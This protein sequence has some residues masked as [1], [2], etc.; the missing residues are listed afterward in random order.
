M[1]QIHES[2][3]SFFEQEEYFEYQLQSDETLITVAEKFLD[4]PLDFY[5]LAKLNNL[6]YPKSIAPGKIL[7]IPGKNTAQENKIKTPSIVPAEVQ[8]D[9]GKQPE[10]SEEDIKIER[11]KVYFAEHRYRE[12]INL[13]ESYANK[14]PASKYAHLKELLAQCYLELANELITKGNLLEAQATLESSVDTL[15]GNQ[16]LQSRLTLVKNQREAERLYHLGL[17]QSHS[18]DE[19]QALETFAK[20]LQFDPKHSQAK[21][22]MID[23]RLTVVEEYHKQAM[24]LYRKQELSRAIEIWDDVLRL[25]PGYE[26][27]KQYRARALEL[28]RKFEQ[29]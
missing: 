23:L 2:P 4:D 24:V 6:D 7:R 18:G 3:D 29:L 16:P 22:Q 17:E 10:K 5:M 28:Q 1:R 11:A 8:P 19:S 27:A 21:K 15:P 14:Q 9:T 13:L 25:D 12:A 26:L 20:A